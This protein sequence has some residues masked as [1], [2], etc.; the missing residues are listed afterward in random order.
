[1][2]KKEKSPRPIK[3]KKGRFEAP[4]PR[5]RSWVQARAN[6]PELLHSDDLDA[7]EN[8]IRT[9]RRKGG[10]KLRD[11]PKRGEKSKPSRVKQT[12]LV[13]PED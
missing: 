7:R 8:S 3:A 4:P 6:A 2:A 12:D 5:D 1:M 9:T 13:E 10:P 11:K